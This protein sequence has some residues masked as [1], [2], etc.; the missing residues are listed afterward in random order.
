MYKQAEIT[1]FEKRLLQLDNY[2]KENDERR[3]HSRR[4]DEEQEISLRKE[5]IVEIGS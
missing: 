5:L 4:V 3:L 1:R 2:D